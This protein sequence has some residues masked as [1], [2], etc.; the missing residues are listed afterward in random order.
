MAPAALRTGTHDQQ[1]ILMAG[2]A[3]Q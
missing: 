3:D 2:E 1:V